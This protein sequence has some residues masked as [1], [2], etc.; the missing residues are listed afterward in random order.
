MPRLKTPE[1]KIGE[2][3]AV[4]EG[5]LADARKKGDSQMALRAL[6]ELRELY[7]AQNQIAVGIDAQKALRT[8]DDAAL[9]AEVK[10][11]NLSLASDVDWRIVEDG[12][13][14]PSEEARPAL[15]ESESTENTF[16]P[17]KAEENART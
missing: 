10:R 16:S 12:S 15:P 8:F 13:Q 6:A 4:A 11:R 2:L 9:I 1:T 7:T 5:V 17:R 3:I 14:L